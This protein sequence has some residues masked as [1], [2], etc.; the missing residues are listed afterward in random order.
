[1]RSVRR[2]QIAGAVVLGLSLGMAGTAVAGQPGASAGNACGVTLNA[3]ST[4]GQAKSAAGSPFNPTGRAGAV[5]A[6]NPGTASLA[7]AASSH[8]VSQYDIACVQVSKR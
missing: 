3:L 7:H 5:Y 4:P 8:A 2:I 1:M 6:G